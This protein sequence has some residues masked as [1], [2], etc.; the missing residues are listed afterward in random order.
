MLYGK[1]PLLR[2]Y[3]KKG[4]KKAW[5]AQVKYKD[6]G[7]K[8]RTKSKTLEGVKSKRAAERAMA[9]WWDELRAEAD[10]DESAPQNAAQTVLEY[11]TAYVD[12]VAVTAEPSTINGYRYILRRQVEPF[13]IAGAGL[14]EVGPEDFRAWLAEVAAKYSAASTS[15]A[16][17][18]VRSAMRQAVNDGRLQR[19]PTD[20]VK[21]PKRKQPEPNAIP[22]AQRKRLAAALAAASQT[23]DVV[24]MQMAL[25]TGMR[26][27]EICALRWRNVDLQGM[28]LDV[29]EA[30][31]KDN[32]RYYVK[33]PKT[34]GSRRTICYPEPL[35]EAL[36]ARR[37]EVSAQCLEA[38]VPF[39]PDMFVLGRID[40]DEATGDYRFYNPHVLWERWRVMADLLG[41]VGTQGKRPTFHDLRHT[42]ATAA[43]AAHVDVKTVSSSLGHANAAMTLNIY[44]D[45][46][47]DA[48]RRGAQAVAEA[49]AGGGPTA[50]IME[51]LPTGTED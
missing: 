1:Q 37:A 11:L 22:E 15:K 27:G 14:S 51:L 24:A 9:A 8:W 29:R 17:V 45:A 7:G 10:R 39:S 4:G 33:E 20:G 12:G 16:F 25:Y 26:E 21:A 3:T 5:R 32:G 36:R 13:E 38:G 48:K 31:G 23:P 47:P 30:I 35:A 34:G 44:A 28:T 41:L 6:D 40:T 19:N 2:E 50:R 46:D 43:I 18:L 42:Y 49:M